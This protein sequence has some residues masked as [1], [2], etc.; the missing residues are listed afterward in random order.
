[1]AEKNTLS[2]LE[3]IKKKMQKFDQKPEGK[4]DLANVIDEFEYSN[5]VKKNATQAVAK[6]D[7]ISEFKDDL[8]LG[9]AVKKVDSATIASDKEADVNLDDFDIDDENS[10][11]EKVGPRDQFDQYFDEDDIEYYEDEVD[12][13]S[14]AQVQNRVNL[15]DEESFILDEDEKEQK[16]ETKIQ[17]DDLDFDD[18][19]F[20]EDEEKVENKVEEKPV[21]DLNLEDD[22]TLPEDVENAANED[23]NS[24]DNP[25]N[26]AI[27]EDELLKLDEEPK[28]IEPT[29]EKVNENSE[30]DPTAEELKKLDDEITAKEV[31]TSKPK[32]EE[33]VAKEEEKELDPTAEELKK[34]DDEITAK[35]VET[36]KPK[37]EEVAITEE[38]KEIDPTAEELKKLDD[39]IKEKEV[40]ASKPKVEE[41]AIKEEKKELDP[42]AEELKKLDDE[43][44]AKEVEASKPKVEEVVAKEEEKEI[45][46]TA[47]E[48]KKLED[49]ITAKEAE[50]SKPKVEE[51]VAK[52]EEKE[53]DPTEEELKKLDD[54]IMAKEVE[55]SKPEV[56]KVAIKEEETNAVAEE[57]SDLDDE[58]EV[59][60]SLEFT[61][62]K[63]EAPLELEEEDSVL[64]DLNKLDEEMKVKE[65]SEVRNILPI[66]KQE[67]GDDLDLGDLK[68]VEKTSQNLTATIVNPVKIIDSNKD[69]LLDNLDLNEVQ[70][71][72]SEESAS[73]TQEITKQPLVQIMTKEASVNIDKSNQYEVISGKKSNIINEDLAIKATESVKKLIDA[74]NMIEKINNFSQNPALAEIALQL[75]EPKLEKWLNENLLQ[76]VEKTVQDEIKKIIPKE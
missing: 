56:E 45:D 3:T 19:M 13:E 18:L 42:T 49:E 67:V 68:I 35:E 62:A 37:V 61:E 65:D 10:F 63:D 6:E 5:P 20:E 75:L 76:I 12:L 57:L 14:E 26:S 32:V 44:T 31:E 71:T 66:A 36:S 55:T 58:I 30:I 52:E 70:E 9:D 4:S 59:D 38:E 60:T 40:E 25:T 33:V 46:P 43:I 29:A 73:V 28:A 17:E 72:N 41:V 23:L 2:I 54:E 64:D 39:E 51:V 7:K 34:L 11:P 8:G 47:E 53:V 74:K 16:P 21:D 69:I 22:L 15:E 50:T 27:E 24:L 1:M 48:L